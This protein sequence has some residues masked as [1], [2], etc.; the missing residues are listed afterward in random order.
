MTKNHK[1]T[2]LYKH[3]VAKYNSWLLTKNTSL[4]S[5][6]INQQVK[7][8]IIKSREILTSVIRCIL[9]STRHDIGLRER[10][11]MISTKDTDNS[12]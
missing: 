1:N 4:V 2:A 7:D 6:Q 9:C 11:K 5:P 10:R 3:P 8:Q 12:N